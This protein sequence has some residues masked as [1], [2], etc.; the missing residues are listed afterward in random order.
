VD[1]EFNAWGGLEDGLYFPWVNDDLVAAKVCELEGVARY[2]APFVLEGG[3]VHVDGEGTCITT[4]ECL[5]NPNRNPSLTR[6]DIE[7]YLRAYL[8]VDTVIWLPRGVFG[9]ETNGHV[10]NLV[11]FSRPGRVLLTWSER[12]GDPQSEISEEAQRVLASTRDARGRSLEVVL[13]PS[14]DLPS[15]TAE[16]ASGIQ[17]SEQARPRLAGDHLAGSYV[18]FFVG[19][20]VVVYPLLDGRYDD[21]V[22]DILANEFPDRRIEGIPAREILLGGGNIHCITQQVPRA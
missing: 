21:A 12:A 11:C 22:A 13:L 2:R 9:D 18:N 15:I 10:D 17:P 20:S 6:A 8:G 1:W 19:N 5:L 7:S 14:P 4:E 16:E 3:S